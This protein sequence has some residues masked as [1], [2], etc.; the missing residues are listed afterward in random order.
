MRTAEILKQTIGRRRAATLVTVVI[1]FFLSGFSEAGEM[2]SKQTPGIEAFDSAQGRHL[3]QLAT[4]HNATI[5]VTRERVRQVE[6]DLQAARASLRPDVALGGTARVNDESSGGRDREETNAFLS[7]SQALYTGGSLTANRQAARLALDAQKAEGVRS[8]QEVLHNVR[9]AYFECLRSLAQVLVAREALTL[10]GEHLR[11]AEALFRAGM[12]PRGDVLRVKVS[13][14]Q[15]ELDLVTAQSNF[16]VSWATL[17]QAVGAK[18]DGEKGEVTS[19]ISQETIDEL[20]PPG[21]RPPSDF[22]ERA[23]AQRAEIA[24]YRLYVDRAGALIRASEGRRSPTV[25]LAGRL[26]SDQDAGS[27]ASNE[28]Y[29]QLDLQ[30]TLYDGGEI[31]SGIRKAKA[32]E[33]ELRGQSELIATQVTQEAAAAEIRLRAALARRNLAQEQMQTSKED[34]RIALRRYDAQMGTNLD[35]L[36]ARRALISGRTEYVN[37][38]YDIA[39]AQAGLIFAMGTDEISQELFTNQ[40]N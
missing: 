40:Q 16:D 34:Y 39:L 37:A 15:S 36:D 31:S 27:L 25:S 23:L 22:L 9:T 13:V 30:W 3:L 26:N 4:I 2:I 24:A 12:A 14:N 7:I 18:L 17:E 21:Y 20:S 32:A 11:Q 29:V 19:A 10:S 6:E 5:T 8:Y 35:V 38:V 33:R 1:F 28:W